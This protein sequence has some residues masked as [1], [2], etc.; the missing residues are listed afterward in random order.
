[1]PGLILIFQCEIHIFISFIPFLLVQGYPLGNRFS[2]S[3]VEGQA[4]PSRAP[5]CTDSV[6]YWVFR[7]HWFCLSHHLVCIMYIFGL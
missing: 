3:L 6:K 5:R 7:E 1:M 2:L 4:A